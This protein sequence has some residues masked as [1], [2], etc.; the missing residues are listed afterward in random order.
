MKESCGNVEEIAYNLIKQA[1]TYL[2]EDI[3][4]SLQKAYASETSEIGKTQLKSVLE[5][6]ALAEK[7]CVPICQ[8]TGTIVFYLKAGASFKHLNKVNEDLIRA[9]RKATIQIPLRPNAVN[10]FSNKNSGDN[11]GRFVPQIHWELVDGNCLEITVM[12]KGGGSEN[13]CV[14][15]M[16]NP[17]EGLNALKRF[18]ID[19]VVKA[20]GQPCPPTILG[21]AVGGGADEAIFLAKKALLT[22]LDKSNEKPELAAL[23]EELLEAVNLTGVGPMG[24]GGINSVL[25]VHVDYA[26]RHPASF[27]VAV[28][29]CCWACRRASAKIYADD[30]VEYL[31]K[32]KR[33]ER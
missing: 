18:V 31:S 6:I 9:T 12:M 16:L 24:L 26:F 23:E 13:A 19:A 5:N 33:E 11:T 7:L 27:P 32:A 22:P 17:G 2:P 3:K 29:F 15:G 14:L 8:D 1:A 28:A 10:P 21:V 20:A 25:K 30:R 4:A